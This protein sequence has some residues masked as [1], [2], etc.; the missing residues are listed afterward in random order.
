MYK[1]G[2]KIVVTA[3]EYDDYSVLAVVRVRKDFNPSGALEE[4]AQREGEQLLLYGSGTPYIHDSSFRKLD[5]KFV[6]FLVTEGYVKKEKISF[7]HLGNH[8]KVS[9]SISECEE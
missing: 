4:F 9:V 2:D 7:L 5:A 8:N 3:G 6:N 1:K